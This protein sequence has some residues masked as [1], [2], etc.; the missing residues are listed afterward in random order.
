MHTGI[1]CAAAGGSSSSS[2][3]F[4]FSSS[5]RFFFAGGGGSPATKPFSAGF[6]GLGP[7]VF[8]F[9]T[10]TAVSTLRT[11]GTHSAESTHTV[12]QSGAGTSYKEHRAHPMRAWHSFAF[13]IH[14]P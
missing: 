5:V 7:A 2:V 9:A 8:S 6:L 1:I 11:Q 4:L 12:A 10:S 14:D 13:N 3:R